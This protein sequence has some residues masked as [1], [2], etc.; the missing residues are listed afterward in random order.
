MHEHD[1]LLDHER[2]D[3]LGFDEAIYAEQKSDEQL[4]ALA[5]EAVRNGRRRF[6]TR[7]TATQFATL[8]AECR[9]V[10]DYD[11]VSRTAFV[12]ERIQHDSNVR[13]AIVSA[14]SSDVP[15]SREAARTL[16][17]HGYSYRWIPDVG[18]AGLWRLMAR[19]DELK[20]MDVVIV[21][22]GMDGALP[23]VV[24][25]L[26]PGVVIALPTPVGYGAGA[27]GRAAL[28][29]TLS[30]CAP[31]LGVVNIGNGYGAACLALRVARVARSRSA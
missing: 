19:I 24:A 11:D 23:S 13:M 12:G 18:V 17:Y 1:I 27:G 22:A 29:A 5:E 15:V 25:G 9:T 3:R 20:T 7:L 2:V 26:V 6:F 10:M 21:A 16:E 8:P 28:A 4:R 30:S 31:G 14:G